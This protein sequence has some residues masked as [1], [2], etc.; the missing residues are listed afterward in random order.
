MAILDKVPVNKNFLSPLNFNFFVR[1]CPHVNFFCQKTNIPGLGF[2][3]APESPNPFLAIKKQGDHL[4][5]DDLEATF[6]VD[7]DMMNYLQLVSWL[8]GIGFP[9]DWSEFADLS[10]KA[11]YTEM[12]LESDILIQILDSNKQPR[13]NVNI[14]DASVVY[15]GG[16]DLD[17]TAENID[18]V[19][20]TA[21]FQYTGYDISKV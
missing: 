15:L 9:N 21:K 17:T 1:K 20:V 14:H 2:S 7:E 13:F 6:K 16:F 18:F 4:E 19:T 5:Y 10:S 12:G 11:R 3:S 8:T